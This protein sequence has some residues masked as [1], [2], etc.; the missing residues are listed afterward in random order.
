[1]KVLPSQLQLPLLPEPLLED[2][3]MHTPEK[4]IRKARDFS[5]S[6]FQRKNNEEGMATCARRSEVSGWEWKY[7]FSP[8]IATWFSSPVGVRK[9]CAEGI[10]NHSEGIE[11]ETRLAHRAIA[12]QNSRHKRLRVIPERGNLGTIWH[13]L[14]ANLSP[15]IL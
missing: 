14:G 11:R 13:I 7:P 15:R 1:M 2:S 6:N 3:L 12:R 5:N 4:I 8:P 9:K 10:E